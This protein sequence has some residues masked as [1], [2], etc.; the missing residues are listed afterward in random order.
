M[1]FLREHILTTSIP[2]KDLFEGR[3]T[4]VEM[5]QL[6]NELLPPV[7]R[8]KS[9]SKAELRK[10]SSYNIYKI[11][12]MENSYRGPRCYFD[13]KLLEPNNRELIFAD[14][15]VDCVI[16][17]NDTDKLVEFIQAM[18]KDNIY[19]GC[20]FGTEQTDWALALN[21]YCNPLCKDKKEYNVLGGCLLGIEDVVKKLTTEQKKAMGWTKEF[22]TKLLEKLAKDIDYRFSGY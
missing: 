9:L 6:L 7:V 18:Q 21:Q 8:N 19:I 17:E 4:E 14:S 16:M 15:V 13:L 10:L 5:E 12:G 2:P 11:D 3:K 1:D 22:E 20:N